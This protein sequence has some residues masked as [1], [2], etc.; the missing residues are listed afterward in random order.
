MRKPGFLT[1]AVYDAYVTVPP[2]VE[3]QDE[4]GRLFDIVSMTAYAIRQARGAGDRLPVAL[5]VRNDN[6][7]PRLVKLVAVHRPAGLRRPAA[8][9]YLDAVM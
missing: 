8:R 2:G 4:I 7:G 6:R 9:H 1:R 3:G 5:Y